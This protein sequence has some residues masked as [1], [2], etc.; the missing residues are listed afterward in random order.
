MTMFVAIVVPWKTW[1]S[2]EGSAP[3]ASGELLHALDRP[4]RR[5]VGGRGEL[6]DADHARLVVDVDEIREGAADVDADALHE[7]PPAV[8]TILPKNSLLSM[9]SIAF[10]ASSRGNVA[11]TC[12]FSAPRAISAKQVSTS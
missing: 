7:A 1:S 5:V 4:L 11:A 10:A 2:D 9:R 6:V 12:G 3:A 8:R